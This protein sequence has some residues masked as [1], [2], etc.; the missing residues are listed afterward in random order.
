VT[1][2]QS[3]K[4]YHVLKDNGVTT[5]FIAYP[6]PG[7]S[8][9]DPVRQ[10]DVDRRWGFPQQE[11]EHGRSSTPGTLYMLSNEGSSPDIAFG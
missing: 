7:H 3:Y 9:T 6:V 2:M 8:P 11:R 5:Q 1:V 10:R 4:L